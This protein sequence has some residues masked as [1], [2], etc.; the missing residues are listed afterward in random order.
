MSLPTYPEYKDSE[1]TWLGHVPAHWHIDRFKVSVTSCKNGIWGD[2]PSDD[3]NDIACVRVAD[4]DRV[5]L[6]VR[7]HIPTLRSV[8]DKE[9][10]GRLLKKGD[11]LLEKSG[12][13]DLQPVGQVVMYHSEMP[14]VCSNFVARMS[15][16]RDMVPAYWNYVHNAAYAVGVNVG[17]INQTSGIQ[18]LDQDRYLNE[19]APFPPSHEQAA[20]ASFLDRET[21]KIVALIAEQEKLLALLAEKR[22]AT[23]SHAVT[24]GLNPDALLN[25]SGV[26]WLGKVPTHWKVRKAGYDCSILSGFAFPSAGFS[27]DDSDVKLLRGVNVGVGALRWNDTV[28]WNR[29]ENDGLD[30]FELRPGDI[31]LGMDRPW[32]SEGLR[33]ARVSESDI[34]CLLLQRVAAIRPG[35]ELNAD[36][37]YYLL[38]AGYFFHH[39]SPEMT[40]VSVPHISPEQIRSFAIPVPPID[41]QLGIVAFVATECAK[42]DALDVEARRS[43]DLLRERRSALIAAAV[44][45]KIDVRDV[46][47]QELAA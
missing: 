27:L 7:D 14:A 34:P 26:T 23:I 20:I 44:T 31:V 43:I 28:Y 8:S 11:L 32:I 10:A 1:V 12:G 39:C 3:G 45:G 16:A 37:L 24:R 47:P 33:V 15:L 36:Y 4:F 22:Q 30:T 5:K 9:R 13:G 21:G 2:E 42:L 35:R 25:D 29:S 38:Q 19:R 41:E 17:A 40:G 18:N 46:A 6:V